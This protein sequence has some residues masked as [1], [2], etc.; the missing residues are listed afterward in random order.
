VVAAGLPAVFQDFGEHLLYRDGTIFDAAHGAA[1]TPILRVD[2]LDETV[3]LEFGWRHAGGCACS[4]CTKARAER[5]EPA[6][7]WGAGLASA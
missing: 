1:E 5:D 6:A 3:G 2:Q 7:V 4:Y